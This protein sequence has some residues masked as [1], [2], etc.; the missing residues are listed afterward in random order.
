MMLPLFKRRWISP[1]VMFLYRKVQWVWIWNCSN[2]MRFAS[3]CDFSFANL[4]PRFSCF[5]CFAQRCQKKGFNFACFIRQDKTKQRFVFFWRCKSQTE[6]N[7]PFGML[8]H[9]LVFCF[10]VC[11]SSVWFVFPRSPQT[12]VVGGW[13]QLFLFWT[14]DPPNPPREFSLGGCE[15]APKA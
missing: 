14:R 1:K 12:A 3:V 13:V 2:S 9:V 11:W 5:R 15:A 8:G 10:R 4:S 7:Q 6:T